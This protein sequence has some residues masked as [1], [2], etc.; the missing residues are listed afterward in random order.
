MN[1]PATVIIDDCDDACACGAC[2]ML[3]VVGDTVFT[4]EDGD[5]KACSRDCFW[6]IVEREDV[7]DDDGGKWSELWV[8]AGLMD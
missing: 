4:D 8:P 1:I 2:Y 7:M 5:T 6:A 3:L